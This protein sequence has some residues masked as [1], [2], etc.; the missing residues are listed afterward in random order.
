MNSAILIV[1]SQEISSKTWKRSADPILRGDGQ[2]TVMQ[3]S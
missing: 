2:V 1:L 3:K